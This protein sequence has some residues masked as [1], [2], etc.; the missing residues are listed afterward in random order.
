MI[1]TYSKVIL[2]LV[3]YHFMRLI[4]K[5]RGWPIDPLPKL[6]KDEK[7]TLNAAVKSL[8]NRWKMVMRKFPKSHKISSPLI[9]LKRYFLI[10]QDLKVFLERKQRRDS[11]DMSEISFGENCPDYFKRN[12]H[13]QT[14]GYCTFEAAARYDH[15]IE[16]LFLG[17][18]HIMR[19]VAYS[20]LDS[21]LKEDASVLEFGAASGTSS[22]Q[23]KLLYPETTLDIL[24]PGEAY[25]D[26]ARE[27]YPGIFNKVIPE[28]MERFKPHKQYD[29]IFSCFVMHEI[30]VEH[31]E[32]VTKTI[33]HA[34]KP[35]GFLLI[36]DA[37]QNNDKPEHQFALDQFAEDFYEPY[38]PEYRENGLE[39]YFKERGFRLLEKSEVLFSKALLF[40]RG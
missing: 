4:A 10:M 3:E 30:P 35:G 1:F 37:Q 16:L 2:Y 33:N 22:Y 36:I 25:L 9:H 17:L 21:V 34:L 20:T 27:T 23:F 19:K 28:F 32:G 11:H 14:G 5:L 24:E 6:T 18:G 39:V 26:Y 38:F 15:Q 40:T 8:L 13:Y 7:S 29:C 31:W 12:Y